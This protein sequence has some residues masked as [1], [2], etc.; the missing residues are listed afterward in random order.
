[1]HAGINSHG[2]D[3]GGQNAFGVFFYQPQAEQQ[4]GNAEFQHMGEEVKKEGPAQQLVF[5]LRRIDYQRRQRAKT[6]HQQQISQP[7]V[8][9]EHHDVRLQSRPSLV[10]M[11]M[12]SRV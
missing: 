4:D 3:D 11:A 12:S 1:M 6:P 10:V 7:L 5:R 9:G 2:D 8:A